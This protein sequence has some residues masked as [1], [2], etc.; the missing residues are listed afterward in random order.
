MGQSRNKTGI[1]FEKSICESKGWTHKSSN[2]Q[3]K[4]N[5]KGRSNFKKISSINF[6]PTKFHPNMEKSKFEKFDVITE[7]GDKV[8]IK[9]YTKEKLSDWNVYSEPIFK[10]ATRSQR[11]VVI[12]LFGGGDFEKSKEVYNNFVKG[13]VD[14]VGDEIL[15]RISGSNIGIQ[16]EDGFI[17]QEDIE[18]RWR[19][20]ES[21]S[22]YNRLSIEFR[23]KSK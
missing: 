21:W 8:E 5:G 14:N 23:V 12:D 2:P 4:W 11:K 10:V 9:K 6:D 22:G 17:P 20:R 19:I 18:Y 1:D 7:S 13:I 16:C 3:I 15:K